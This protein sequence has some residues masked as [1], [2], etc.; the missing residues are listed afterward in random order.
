M[1]GRARQ[2]SMLIDKIEHLENLVK[3]KDERIRDLE[4]DCKVYLGKIRQLEFELDGFQSNVAYELAKNEATNSLLELSR[5]RAEHEELK[6][7]A[8]AHRARDYDIK[9]DLEELVELL[10]RPLVV[11]Y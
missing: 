7:V 11:P 4:G 9:R 2:L 1:R 3:A 6:D 5:L 8:R 10:T